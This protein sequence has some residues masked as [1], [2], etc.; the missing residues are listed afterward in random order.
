MRDLAERS[1]QRLE[2]ELQRTL[3]FLKRQA[4]ELV[5]SRLLLIGGGALLPQVD[6]RLSDRLQ[7]PTTIWRLPGGRKAEGHSDPMQAVFAS[8]IALST[9]GAAS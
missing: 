7:T 1:L 6:V 8:A 3:R 2:P 5:P 4:K 9:L